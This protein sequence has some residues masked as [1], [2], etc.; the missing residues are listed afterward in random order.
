MKGDTVCLD[1]TDFCSYSITVKQDVLS[2][3]HG[4][5]DLK[6]LMAKYFAVIVT[7]NIGD[8]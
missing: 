2:V 7:V 4:V 3:V 1:I 6:H 8:Y 5:R